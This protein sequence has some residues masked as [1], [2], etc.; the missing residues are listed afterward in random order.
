MAGATLRWP[1]TKGLPPSMINYLCWG[2]KKFY[3]VFLCVDLRLQLA[4]EV[5]GL[6]SLPYCC[7]FVC[8]MTWVYPINTELASKLNSS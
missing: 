6:A 4:S 1:S 3:L 5:T 7:L 2:V 8:R